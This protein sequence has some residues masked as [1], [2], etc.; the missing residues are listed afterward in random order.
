MAT[1]QLAW[2]RRGC[3]LPSTSTSPLILLLFW[4]VVTFKIWLR[5]L[6]FLVPICCPFPSV[7]ALPFHPLGT[8]IKRW[9]LQGRDKK[10]WPVTRER[11]WFLI[12]IY[13]FM[14]SAKNWAISFTCFLGSLNIISFTNVHVLPHR[15]K[16]EATSCLW[17]AIKI[18]P[19]R[20]N[21][22]S[23]HPEMSGQEQRKKT[24]KMQIW[25]PSHFKG[26]SIT[27]YSWFLATE[28]VSG[29]IKLIEE[30]NSKVRYAPSTVRELIS[31]SRDEAQRK[32]LRVN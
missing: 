15:K 30:S 7:W 20:A 32:G 12:Y 11:N 3:V 22:L 26:T 29:V 25:T 4:G 1:W 28:S 14:V 23:A 19:H 6:S 24:E 9:V 18:K 31:S 17:P 8:K 10:S 2:P 27:G 5:T 21:C 16:K 13:F